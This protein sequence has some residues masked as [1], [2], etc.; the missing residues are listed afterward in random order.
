LEALLARTV[1]RVTRQ[2]RVTRRTTCPPATVQIPAGGPPDIGAAAEPVPGGGCE[3]CGGAAVVLALVDVEME[4][5]AA[6]AADLRRDGRYH[7]AQAGGQL[8]RVRPGGGADQ[9]GETCGFR[10]AR[11]AVHVTRSRQVRRLTTAMS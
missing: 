1:A 3:A 5:G 4:G 8:V 6:V 11:C 7:R 2:G 9:R 10:P